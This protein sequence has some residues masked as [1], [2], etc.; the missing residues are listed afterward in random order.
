MRYYYSPLY[1]FLFV[2]S[3]GMANS[4]QAATP[5]AG[6][7]LQ[8]F[9]L[10]VP[11]L[12]R[13]VTALGFVMGMAFII[14]GILDLKRLGEA[15]T[16]M[17]SEK[18]IFG[19]VMLIIVGTLL[20]Y[21]P[22]AV[23]VGTSTFWTSTTPLAYIANTNDPWHDIIQDAY[24]VMQLIGTVA[25]IRGLIL[26]TGISQHSQHGVFG[27]AMAYIIAGILCI[28]IYPFIQVV[29]NTLSL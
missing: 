16:M 5:N 25:F 19:P 17:S 21:L 22:S 4:T 8:N 28:N 29:E 18:S 7:M 12:I 27:K 15:R 1:Y 20:L 11:Q 24:L 6:T 14:K 2:F 23:R 3:Y 9:A 10:N 13:L 26:L